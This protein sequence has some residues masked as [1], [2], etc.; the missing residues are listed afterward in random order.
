MLDSFSISLKERRGDL[1]LWKPGES[2]SFGS[3]ATA[4]YRVTSGCQHL[5]AISAF[6]LVA[7]ACCQYIPALGTYMLS[8][9]TCSQH[10]H[11][12]STCVLFVKC[13]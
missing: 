7:Y 5:H 4:R 10:I 6:M 9:D 1:C 2:L 8:V 3:M 11:V 13:H 12:S